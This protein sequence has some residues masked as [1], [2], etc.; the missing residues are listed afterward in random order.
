MANR[1]RQDLW[2]YSIGDVGLEFEFTN[3][4]RSISEFVFELNRLGLQVVHDASN[5]TPALFIK[6]IPVRTTPGSD[7][8]NLLAGKL[9]LNSGVIGGEA[10]SNIYETDDQV[11]KDSIYSIMGAFSKFGETESCTRDSLHVH[12]NVG[13]GINHSTLLR[14]LNM[15]IAYEYIL[16]KLGGMGCVNRGI[17]NSFI[18]QRPYTPKGPPVVKIGRSNYPIFYVNDLSESKNKVNFF[19]ILGDSGY[20]AE[21]GARYVTQRY[22]GVNF[23]SILTT[24]SI[25]FRH[26]NKTLNPQW[27]IAWT[28]LCSALV[29]KAF[30]QSPDETEGVMRPLTIGYVPEDDFIS[31]L[32]SFA[33]LSKDSYYTLIEMWRQCE[34][35]KY[36]DHWVYSHLDNPT[37]HE[38]K[39]NYLPHALRDDVKVPNVFTVHTL[40]KDFSAKLE[41]AKRK[42][43]AYDNEL[44][45]D[46]NIGE[47]IMDNMKIEI[48]TKNA[49]NHI[50]N[51]IMRDS[52]VDLLSRIDFRTLD[53][54]RI[55]VDKAVAMSFGFNKIYVQFD[56][57]D[58]DDED[59]HEHFT[60]G[61]V[62]VFLINYMGDDESYY[63]MFSFDT[64]NDGHLFLNF[65]R[66]LLN[67]IKVIKRDEPN[68]IDLRNF[69][70]GELV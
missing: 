28:E 19:N 13:N 50:N 68:V 47:R 5:E 41:E 10:V 46:D 15:S 6:N 27:V 24:G 29:K 49:Q 7:D 3:I 70:T 12:V 35:I 22:M 26:A 63:K 33:F 14:L 30:F 32:G 43:R 59:E 65:K 45:R 39:E 52:G 53:G 40:T 2:R 11:W 9:R 51:S 16:Y 57:E 25:E 62:Y 66:L 17:E 37:F 60:I 55:N 54:V 36:Q 8:F 31:V 56:H 67:I 4:V 1:A 20:F 44:I 69:D 18:Y 42:G 21:N 34:E 61:N 64:R 58:Y 48:E 38:H 23:Y